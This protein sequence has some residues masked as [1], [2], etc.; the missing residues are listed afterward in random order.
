MSIRELALAMLVLAPLSGCATDEATAP[1]DL[2]PQFITYGF[3]DTGNV[4]GN[5]GAYIVKSPTGQIFPICSGTL[6]S[7]TVF[8]TAA[9][10]TEFFLRDLAPIGYTAY[11]SF[12]SPIGFGAKT[13]LKKTRLIPVLETVS[14]PDFNQRQSDSGDIGVLLLPERSTRGITPAT[15]PT[16]GLLDQLA[17]Q[18]VLQSATFTAVG[19][20]VQERVVGGGL[21]FFQDLNPI[22]RMFAF[23]SF[24]SLGPGYLRL[25]QNPSTGS[26]GTCFGDSG[27]PNFL[28]L[29]GQLILVA[30]T[31][32]GD[33]VCRS[34][35]VDY[36]LDTASARAFLGQ[37][38][39]LP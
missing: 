23:S 27:G 38:V 30:T 10:C 22:P 24:N 3:T 4:Y 18:H 34:T 37:F 11:V 8:L 7:S 2:H 6:I 25:S 26:G 13:D 39:R 19:Y 36:R 5:V 12:S 20:G 28:T 29:N 15:L 14:N 1:P 21:P 31:V 17:A 35:N 9:H 33:A 32:T 16:L